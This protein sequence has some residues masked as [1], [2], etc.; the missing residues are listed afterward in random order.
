MTEA[1]PLLSRGIR[2]LLVLVLALA[3]ATPTLKAR[4]QDVAYAASVSD[5]DSTTQAALAK[6][7]A[8][9]RER[10]L[11]IDPLVAKVREGRLKRA[12]GPRIRVAVERLSE[13]LATAREALGAGSSTDE[14]IAG[15]DA[16]AVGARAASLRA[17]RLATTRSVTAATGA[18]AQ[19]LASGVAEPKAV[20]M[21][22]GLLRRNASPAVLVALGNQV[23][24]DVAT[25]LAADASATFRLR[26]LEG[27]LGTT[28]ATAADAYPLSSA[29]RPVNG[30]NSTPRRKP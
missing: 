18:L 2:A 1:T 5:L 11:P 7:I 27:G 17:L 15:A 12:T 29:P 14:L 9:A 24:A 6:E 26:A 25:G 4:G 28:A 19:L 16:I 30:S 3:L 10:G 22:I 23:E 8:R 21:V 20:E 13:R